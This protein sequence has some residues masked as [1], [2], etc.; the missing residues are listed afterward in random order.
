LQVT[1]PVKT[2]VKT[3]DLILQFLKEQPN[4]TLAEVAEATSK[5]LSAIE[6]ASAKLVKTGRLKYIGPKKGGRWEVIE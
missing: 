5:S 2:P 6:R 1:G 3:Q 4:R